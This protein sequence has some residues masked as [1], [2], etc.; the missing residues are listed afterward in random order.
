MSSVSIAARLETALDSWR[1]WSIQLRRRPVVVEEIAGGLTNRTW[2]LE[3]DCGPAI[4]RLD[5]RYSR[6]LGIDR[7]MESRVLAAVSAAGVAPAVWF[8]DAGEG[9]LVSAFI[10]GQVWSADDLAEPSKCARLADAI[11]SY[12]RLP[13]PEGV[14]RFDYLAHLD[15]Y[16][17][18]L[19]TA[20]ITDVVRELNLLYERWRP[21]IARW[22][23]SGWTPAL[24]HHDLNPANIIE[25]A[26]GLYIVD[27]EYAGV[28]CPQLDDLMLPDTEKGAA[29]APAGDV[30]QQKEEI[31][32]LVGRLMTDFWY[33]VRE[34]LCS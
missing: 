34:M 25:S 18:Q 15:H 33:P 7:A 10:D 3:T 14:G 2:R 1:G 20:G 9:V 19:A 6:L 17:R 22:Q 4:L 27:W 8:N 16:R 29:G 12:R 28:G 32:A 24:T 11:E 5:S 23:E 26:G 21:A 30:L 13:L 31:T